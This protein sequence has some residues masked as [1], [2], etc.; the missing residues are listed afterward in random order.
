MNNHNTFQSGY[1]SHLNT[2]TAL[3]KGSNNVL[4]DTGDCLISI[5]EL[6]SAFD[7]ADHYILLI[8]IEWP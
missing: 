2:D 3:I 6:S 7:T 1:H 8:E 5:I 4:A